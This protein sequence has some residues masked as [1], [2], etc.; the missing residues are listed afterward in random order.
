M[1]KKFEPLSLD[2][3]TKLSYVSKPQRTIKPLQ[4]SN[5]VKDFHKKNSEKLTNSTQ[6][7]VSF[8]KIR[9]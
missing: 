3:E 1:S 6:N 5:Q 7:K 8:K 2:K 4:M 9:L